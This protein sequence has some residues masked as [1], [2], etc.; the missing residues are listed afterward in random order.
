VAGAL[1]TQGSSA[2]YSR[3]A[4]AVYQLAIQGRGARG[5]LVPAKD[6]GHDLDGMAAAVT[7]DTKIVFIANPNNPTGTHLS[8]AALEAFLQRVPADVAVVLDE[9][10]NEYLPPEARTD[11]IAWLAKYRNL[12]ISRTFSKAYGLAGLRVGYGFMA[13]EVA[14]LLNRLRQ[15]FNVNSLALAAAT[16]ALGDA[17][18]VRHSYELNRQGMAQLERGL[19]E[20]GLNWIKSCGNF[21]SFELPRKNGQPQ[22]PLVYQSLLKLGVIVRAIGAYEMPD[23]LRVTVGT[24]EENHIFLSALKKAMAS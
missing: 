1:L 7:K 21:I 23:H 22:A 10:Y 16:A 24:M 4:F 5:I 13:P 12:I 15:P 3:H 6:Y 9:A 14:D 18:F 20:L 2:V 19:R 11:S 8:G 17:E